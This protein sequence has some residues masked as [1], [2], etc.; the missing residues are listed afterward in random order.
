K[1][2]IVYSGVSV[3]LPGTFK[4]A[5]S[6]DNF[7]IIFK[8]KNLIEKLTDKEQKSILDLNITRL[9]KTES[10]TTLKQIKSVNEVIQFAGKFGNLDMI[11][12]YQIDEG[13][14][15]AMTMTVC[16]GI[17]AG[18]EALKDAGIPLIREKKK[19]STG[20]LLSG[21][22][23]LPDEMRDTTGII[24]ANGLFPLE[25]VINEVSKYIA[26]KY[27][28]RTRK[29][30]I[31]F[32]SDVIDSI[33]DENARMKLTDW[34]NSHYSRLMEKSEKND[35][36]E[37]NHHF[38]SLL[39]SQANNRLAQ[40]IGATGPN[41]YVSA[42]CSSTASAVTVAE[43]M[44][45]AGHAD[46]MI[47]IGADIASIEKLLPWFGAGFLSMGSLTDS[48]D[49]FKSAVPFDNRRNGMILGSGAV[50]LVLEKEE[51]VEKRGMNG[52][53]R[54]LGTHLFNSA[55]H[56]SRI[57]TDKHSK[58][59]N[60]FLAK[61][62]DEHEID[63]KKIALKTVYCSH[64]TYSPKNGGCAE[65]EKIALE[66]AFEEKYREI[67][68]INTKGF[69]GHTMG[70][71]IEDAVSAKA[72]QYQKIPPIANYREPDPSLNGLNLSEGG[73]YNFD[74]ILRS[75]IA[76]GGQGNYHLLQRIAKGDDR[77][78]NKG[79]YN[80]W[81]NKISASN[82]AK[83]KHE[84]RILT[85][86]EEN[87]SSEMQK[88]KDGLNSSVKTELKNK[89]KDKLKSINNPN[90]TKSNQETSATSLEEINK[91]VLDI[92]SQ[93]T[94]Y[95]IEMLEPDMELEADLGIDTV[96]QATIFSMIAEKYALSEDETVSLSNYPTI[97]HVIEM[98]SEKKGNKK[99]RTEPN[100]EINSMD[101]N[102]NTLDKDHVKTVDEKDV[103]NEIY[104]ILSEIT[105]YP[106]EM[107]EKDM[108]MEA[109]LGIDTV[110]QATIFSLVGEKYNISPEKVSGMSEY[111]TIDEV[112]E[113][114]KKNNVKKNENVNNDL[115]KQISQL[116]SEITK[117]PSE[118]L[119]PDMEFEADLGIDTIKQATIFSEINSRFNIDEDV[120]TQ[121]NQFNTIGSL[122]EMVEKSSKQISGVGEETQNDAYVSGE[123]ELLCSNRLDIDELSE[124]EELS[125]Q[126]PVF[127]EKEI[128]EKNYDLKDK[129]IWIIGNSK[130]K[131]KRT[132][133]LFINKG[134]NIREFIFDSDMDLEKLNEKITD[135]VKN[136]V[137]VIV[138][139]NLMDEKIHPAE[140]SGPQED[141][142]LFL[143]SE[144]RFLFY[145]SL[146]IIKDNPELNIIC[147]V[148]LDGNHGF[149]DNNDISG[150]LFN[151][152]AGAVTG[153]YK[154][155]R[156]EWKDS[157]IKIIDLGLSKKY[158]F[159]NII[160]KILINELENLS[161]DYEIGY[162]D[163]K[164][165]VFKV[166]YLDRKRSEINILSGSPHFV[167]TGGGSGIT[168]QIV[169][170]L[171]QKVN[172]KFT[173]I[174]RTKLPTNIKD[175]SRLDENELQ[176]RKI[177]IL[178]KLKE[179]GSD[180]S[181][182]MVEKEYQKI[183]KAISVYRLI[184]TIENNGGTADYYDC[185]V[186]DYEK[187]KLSLNN[188]VE[189]NGPIDI[190]IH[191]AGLEKSQLITEKTQDEFR[192]VFSVKA[193]GL[194]NLYHLIDR[195]H[196]KAFISFSSISGRFGNEAQLDYCSAN[197]FLSSFNALVRAQNQQI[198]AFCIAWSGW[199]D[200]GMAW[201]NEFVKQH[202][203]EIGI[204]LIDVERGVSE[205]LQILNSDVKENELIIS[206]G[207]D[208]FITP[209]LLNEN[210]IETPMIDWFS[211][212]ND[213][214]EKAY[215]VLSVKRDPIINNHRLGKVPL[216]PAVGFMEMLAEFHSVL[217]GR[218]EQYCFKD[219]TLKRPLKLFHENPQ[220]I[221][222]IPEYSKKK[223]CIEGVFYNNFVFKNGKTE[224]SELNKMKICSNIE[225]SD[226]LLK[227]KNIIKDDLQK[228]GSK[229]IHDL[230]NEE[231]S[232]K[233]GSLFMDEKSRE[234]S[235]FEYNESGAV[236]K[237]LLSSEQITNKKYKLDNLLL[238]PVFMDALFQ[239]CGIHSAETGDGVYLPWNIGELAVIKPA[240]K[241]KPY[242][243][244]AN[245]KEKSS[246]ILI[247]DV[248]L[249]N[250]E[251]KICYYSKNIK[252]RRINL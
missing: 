6:D 238:N 72:L 235:C 34:F 128:G 70:A 232:I 15:E 141:I 18:Y 220:E 175:L 234:Y 51:D 129:N 48:S 100:R 84:G 71:S 45:R 38:M 73:S 20:T 23:V 239:V 206:K 81:L 173:I 180:Y 195:D 200:T 28:S 186:R 118:M 167:V 192:N 131:V 80:T 204:N 112:I 152:Y 75:V 3:G 219:I 147:L 11:A 246:D 225:E 240:R 146:S 134:N 46:R 156:K 140:I 237:F 179:E 107:L 212:K 33:S 29:D 113:F 44:I 86:G 176:D 160:D 64:E 7:D 252:M 201:R 248:V 241:V 133:S 218:K 221:V 121:T 184:N 16:A 116:I 108:E 36:Y 236:Y 37:F 99:E 21:R 181:P 198:T 65:T 92:Y 82:D 98:L 191:A 67:K 122:I 166:D 17:A 242:T 114:V 249:L 153:F 13:K 10:S 194:C 158:H 142:I 52:I 124:S 25:S 185:D 247:Y 193:K 57:D 243:A 139:I 68:V 50:G 170:G 162:K 164:R 216:M 31:N 117:Y 223:D 59:L 137:D 188:T 95:P 91:D 203:E 69:T 209:E 88:N 96:K 79:K 224:L 132:K 228:S 12:D 94:K 39:S 205:F 130:D 22:L 47:V 77:I 174:G 1:E 83:L 144:V 35:I 97:G 104:K 125:I 78:V 148:S 169:E 208:Y 183:L 119:E 149:A 2:K 199:K 53:C 250:N 58:E 42:A 93:V 171:S 19:S 102:K 138:D 182:V 165:M 8:G 178:N 172:G 9:L 89:Q 85:I 196:L 55:G 244:Y 90:I 32:Y 106:P 76:F 229:V 163:G 5:F 87:K 143:H 126:V 62:E 231:I 111:K 151:P 154:G 110:K 177:E 40:L 215:K 159:E 217:F 135:F 210:L 63:R 161:S 214:L 245:L 27:G 74:Y 115:L 190:I 60:R 168:A 49:L 213:R 24:F 105:K 56:Q 227:L 155:L 30:L 187:M 101:S 226:E 207:L 157:R 61:M 4:N 54:I 136:P 202:S 41:L 145:K 233:L 103:E 109:D 123:Q 230:F 127:I 66:S 197:S 189:K 120:S 222:L 150:K 211:K 14:L 251:E 26:Y 43:D